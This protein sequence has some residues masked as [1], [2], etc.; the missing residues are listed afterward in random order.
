MKRFAL[1]LGMFGASVLRCRETS[2]V[3]GVGV[4]LLQ[5]SPECQALQLGLPAGQRSLLPGA[6]AD[7]LGLGV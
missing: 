1:R 7:S 6:K 2:A 3:G 5:K 4:R